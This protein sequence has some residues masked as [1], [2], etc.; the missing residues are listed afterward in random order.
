MKDHEYYKPK[1]GIPGLTIGRDLIEAR[2]A[3]FWTMRPSELYSL[4]SDEQAKLIAIYL[5]ENAIESYYESEKARRYDDIDKEQK[6][7]G[8]L[9]H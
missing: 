2:A 3:R 9:P 7:K 6:A 8:S 5:A 4:E 1:D